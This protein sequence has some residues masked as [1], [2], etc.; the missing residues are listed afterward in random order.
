MAAS[1][2]IIVVS[3]TLLIYWFRYTCLLMLRVRTNQSYAAD[4][5]AANSLTFAGIREH[6]VRGAGTQQLSELEH[7]LERDYR[8]LTYLLDHAAGVRVGGLTLEQ[9]MLMIDFRLMQMVCRLTRRFA[10]SRAR[11]A[12]LE[13]SEV[14]HYLANDM[15]ARLHATS[16]G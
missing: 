10:A 2:L 9:R 11:T 4:V 3:A 12:V 16:R 1:I 5:A 14:L 13:M 8:M 7:A 15:G 6:A